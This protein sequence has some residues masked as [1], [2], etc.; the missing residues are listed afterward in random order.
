MS[1]V[2]SSVSLINLI[3]YIALPAK[4]NPSITYQAKYFPILG[5]NQNGLNEL[6]C[7]NEVSI[8][9]VFSEIAF[10]LGH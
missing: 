3:F 1:T 9:C 5:L 4:Q 8:Y 7:N 6:I 10:I 2:Y